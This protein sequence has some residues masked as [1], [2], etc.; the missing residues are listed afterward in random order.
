MLKTVSYKKVGNKKLSE[1][2][3]LSEVKSS[4]S[5]TVK[6]DTT[7][8]NTIEKVIKFFNC[9]K[10]IISSG[11]RTLSE[12]IALGGSNTGPHVAGRAVDI[13]FYDAKGKIIPSAKIVL[14]LEDLGIK[15]IAVNCG[16]NKNYTHFDCNHRINKYYGDEAVNFRS[17]WYTNSKYTSFY[18]YV[19]NPYTEPKNNVQKGDKGN[20]VFWVQ[21]HLKRL[22]YL[23]GVVIKG[24][25]GAKT[26][27]AVKQFKKD[28]QVTAN[29]KPNGVVGAGTIKKLKNV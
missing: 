12:E 25:F 23:K 8:I 26:E 2:V 6:Y 5:D 17:I 22:G 19:K 28:Y 24:V 10:C 27:K 7:T 20:D 29:K 18:K 1:H 16:G 9:S 14:Y 4:K 13:A 11:Y 15:G 3:S 21:F